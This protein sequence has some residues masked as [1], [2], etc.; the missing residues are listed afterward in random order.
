MR[1]DGVIVSV[2][3]EAAVVR[4]K[5]SEACSGCHGSCVGC[6]KVSFH[7]IVADNRNGA[8]VDEE[9]YVESNSRVIYLLVL[10][11]YLLP[12]ITMPAVYFISEP[13]LGE[14]LSAAL[15]FAAIIVLFVTL[16]LTACKRLSAKIKYSIIRK[17]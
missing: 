12:V 1:A 17:I 16:Y 15:A 6:S 9:V 2:N 10:L 5:Q 7:E 11:L 13:Y 3:G 14:A 4:I 8:C